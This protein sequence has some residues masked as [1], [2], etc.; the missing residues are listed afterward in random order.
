MSDDVLFFV[1]AAGASVVLPFP[2]IG[3]GRGQGGRGGAIKTFV[4]QA[5]GSTTAVTPEWMKKKSPT[6][7]EASSIVNPFADSS[8]AAPA[9]SAAADSP[10]TPM[11]AESAAQ[12][13]IDESANPGTSVVH[14]PVEDPSADR[15]ATPMES[16]ESTSRSP[17]DD[18]FGGSP[19]DA[20]FGG[21]NGNS[22]SGYLG[23]DPLADAFGGGD[24]G[25]SGG[26]LAE[27]DAFGNGGVGISGGGLDD[28]FGSG[29]V[30][31]LDAFDGGSGGN[32][33]GL[34]AFGGGGGGGY[35]LDDFT[36]SGLDDTFGGALAS[37]AI[38]QVSDAA[39]IRLLVLLISDGG[40]NDNSTVVVRPKQMPLMTKRQE[41][42]QPLSA[43]FSAVRK[44]ALQDL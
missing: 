1:Q 44:L 28:T 15:T 27:D 8:P 40:C 5:P 41:P 19:L 25:T 22:G 13:H 35:G 32:S 43:C 11:E 3:R 7:E 16:Q 37:G 36:G 6:S 38:G 42:T 33:G 26:G 30:G 14:T 9:E 34:D 39:S 31:S 10:A 23:S 29:D 18:A 4:P 2:G 12:T 20:A 21:G 17:M 24:A